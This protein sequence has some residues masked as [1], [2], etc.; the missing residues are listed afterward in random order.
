MENEAKLVKHRG[1]WAVRLN[2]DRYS[3]GLEATPEN[4]E[5]AERQASK[6]TK[7]V[8]YTP[9]GGTCGEI[10][11]AYLA[12]K[13][14]DGKC[15]RPDNLEQDWKQAASHFEHLTPEE[16]TR[17]YA[18]PTIRSGRGRRMRRL[19]GTSRL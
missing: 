18:E 8:M 5:A 2:G 9:Q 7:Q 12:D 17:K 13:R 15:V 10:M 16:V 1:K 11:A 4:R 14:D 3:T 19:T 6:I